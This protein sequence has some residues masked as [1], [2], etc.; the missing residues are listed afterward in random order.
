M[1]GCGIDFG[2]SNSMIVLAGPD[3]VQSIRLDPGH[4][5]PELAPTLMF[6]SVEGDWVFGTAARQE[7]LR[8]EMQGR[9]IQ[10]I[11]KYLPSQMFTSTFIGGRRLGLDEIIAQFLMWLR[12]LASEQ[13]G[14]E[15]TRVLMGRP[16][17]FHS[18]P[19]RDAF[20]QDRLES[21][22]RLAGFTT[23]DFRREP[24][25]AARAFET[26]LERD[27]LCL[28][29]DLGGGTSD[30]TVMRLGPGRASRDRAR[31]VL[32]FDGVSIAGNDLDAAIVRAAVLP[33]LGYR[34]TWRIVGK[35]VEVPRYLHHAAMSWHELSFAST[36]E[37]LENLRRWI[38][39]ADDPEGLER[40]YDLLRWNNGFE[41]FQA[42]ESCKRVLSDQ[43]RAILEL[44]VEGI[45]L[46]ETVERAAFEAAI[47]GLL[48]KLG[49]CMDRLLERIDLKPRDID[50]VFLTGGTSLVPAVRA[51]F[52][53]RFPGRI[54][55]G[56]AFTSVGH[57]LGIEALERL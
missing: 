52:A 18:D 32:G 2:T 37:N 47:A 14:V 36:R 48:G 7:F 16:A 57:G 34:S 56:D 8:Q 39:T 11:K 24:I 45:D 6:S 5:P 1:Y 40:L 23:V 33:R 21:A 51:L 54:L 30:F 4:V 12:Q 15:V 43:D 38:Q 55:P 19:A 20:A 50:V 46:V 27:V 25:A 28:V 22:A 13:A 10:S 35:H 26:T 29:G 17:V 53:S 31:D 3:G 42:V 9:F 41:L 44:H 49:A